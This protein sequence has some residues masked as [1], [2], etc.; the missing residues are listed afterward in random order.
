MSTSA[1][2]AGQAFVEVSLKSKV[3]EGARQIQTQ[4]SAVSTGLKSFGSGIA[5]A[6]AT[7]TAMFGSIVGALA[8]PTMLAAN[9][10]TTRAGFQ[11][12]LG[13]GEKVNSLMSDLQK[14]AAQTPFEFPELAESARM[15]LAFGVPLNE[16]IGTLKDVGDVSSGINAPLGEI[17]EIFGKA[18]VQG[19]LFMEDINQLT[20]RGIPIIQELAKQFGVSE[21]EVR[22]LVE[23]GKV[24]FSHLQRAFSDLTKGSGIFANQMEVKSKTLIG[25]F[26]SLKDNVGQALAPIGESLVAVL[27]PVVEFAGAMLRPISDF[28]AA[29]RQ[30]VTVVAAV[31][32]GGTAI[33]VA[34]LTVGGTLIGVA[35]AIG[36]LGAA[37]PAI[38]AGFTAISG[39]ALP[40]VAVLAGLAGNVI[41]VTALAGAI[42]YLAN[43]AGILKPAFDELMNL[44]ARMGAIA[45]QTF[46]GIAD[47]L[48]DGKISKAAAILWAGVKVA[49]FTGAKASYDA[50]IW[51]FENAG[52]LLAKFATAVTQTF[53]DIF[54]QIPRLIKAALSGGESITAI[55]AE[56]L[57]GNLGPMLEGQ[58]KAAQAELDALTAKQAKAAPQIA[59][60]TP[61][62]AVSQATTG[63]DGAKAFEDRVQAL[64]DEITEMNLGAD[65]AELLKLKQQ[66][67]NDEQL[68][69]IEQLQ[70]QRNAIQA[71]KKTRE[72]AQKQAE[73]ER[74]S[75]A[76]RAKQL[77]EDARTPFEV[78]QEKIA[79]INRLQAGGFIDGATAMRQRS[80]AVNEFG[81]PMREAIKSGR[82]NVAEVHTQAALDILIR[83][84]RTFGM[85]VGTGKKNPLEDYARE[86][87][88]L[89][90]IIADQ[91]GKTPGNITVKTRTI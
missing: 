40:V 46:G 27:K 30:L 12:M 51:L 16:V 32:V 54:G 83:N 19:R 56:T 82:N 73:D 26:S 52:S 4:L 24:N 14:F 81:Q 79:E 41:H 5:A 80:A 62:A 49:F 65:A 8:W 91:A 15:L 55:I 7:A 76:D 21:A 45:G 42:M 77:T 33:G 2:R 1:V 86:Q 34:L 48:G 50:F 9:M 39:V 11:A 44:F 18:R 28:I 37:I 71:D 25:L 78:M 68:K 36:G 60:T 67:L 64:R 23:S 10:E 31:A 38:V 59:P 53:A 17:A 88:D 13:D 47:A 63:P 70:A 3:Q 74:K 22:K 69:A 29:N 6:G 57:K 75:L 58:A 43:R 66:G 20:G 61:S 89:L 85:G 72:D 35:G 87:R 90:K 84:Q